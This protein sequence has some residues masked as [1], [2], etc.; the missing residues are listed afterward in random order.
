ML[1]DYLVKVENL[2]GQYQ[3]TL[4]IILD[5]VKEWT[6]RTYLFQKE[7]KSMKFKIVLSL[8]ASLAVAGTTVMMLASD[9]MLGKVLRGPLYQR[10]TFS[11][12]VLFLM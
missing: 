12:L 2:G 11:L 9:E 10:T 4:N 8:T 5:D 7:R 6:E 3:S 1:H